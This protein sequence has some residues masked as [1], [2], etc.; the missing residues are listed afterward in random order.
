MTSQFNL[1]ISNR[2]RLVSFAP[3]LSLLI[4]GA[5]LLSGAQAAVEPA[6][7]TTQ[8][9]KLTDNG[10]SISWTAAEPVWVDSEYGHLPTIDQFKNDKRPGHFQLPQKTVTFAIP[11][12]AIIQTEIRAATPLTLA[13]RPVAI[14]PQP[15]G[16]KKNSKG[17]PIGGEFEPSTIS[18]QPTTDLV[19]ITEIGTMAGVRLATATFS[20]L[21]PTDDGLIFTP[22]A[23]VEITFKHIS[24]HRASDNRP[25]TTLQTALQTQVVN[26]DHIQ[27][28][29]STN[30]PVKRSQ[31]S[32]VSA[33]AVIQISGSGMVQLTQQHLKDAGLNVNTI[34]P[35]TLSLSHLGNTV[36][37]RWIGNSD[38]TFSTT[39]SLIFFAPEFHS[40][41]AETTPILL[42]LGSSSTQSIGTRTGSPSSSPSGALTS[43]VVIEENLL[44][45]PDCGCK[46]LP[47]GWDG[48]RWMWT[49][50]RRQKARASSSTVEAQLQ[51]VDVSQPAEMTVHQIGFTSLSGVDPDHAVR[52]RLNDTVLGTIF[53]DGKAANS[54]TFD[55]PAGLLKDA[56]TVE[57]ELIEH[58][59]EDDQPN[60][61]GVWLDALEFSYVETDATVTAQ[62]MRHGAPSA[63]SYSVNTAA[64][65]EIYDVTDP[66]QPLRLTDPASSSGS[67]S[68]ADTAANASYVLVPAGEYL[69]PVSIQPVTGI[70][71][72]ASTGGSYV[73]IAPAAFNQSPELAA[74]IN[75][76]QNQGWEVVFE[77]VEEIYAAFGSGDPN[78][79]SIQSYFEWGYHNWAVTPEMVLLVGDGS[80]DPKQ[81]KSGSAVTR[82]PP[83][84]AQV[85]PWLG[86][87]AAD[88]RFVTVDGNDIL[89]DMAIGRLPAN[90]VEELA[91]IVSKILAYA[92]TEPIGDWNS[93]MLIVADNND[94]AGDFVLSSNTLIA[95]HL[96]HPWR[97]SRHYFGVDSTSESAS[98]AEILR[99]WQGG[100]G[101]IMYTGHSSVHQWGSERL[102]HIDD[103]GNLKN[104]GRLPLVFQMTCFTGSY[105][106][107][108]FN[109]LDEQLVRQSDGG[110]IAVWGATGLGVGTGHDALA[111][112]AL[113]SIY[114]QKNPSLGIALLAGKVQLASDEPNALDLLDTFN[115]LGDPALQVNLQLTG[116]TIHLPFT[117][118]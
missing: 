84:L 66:Y 102:I 50:M 90:S 46:D 92:T 61:D 37:F 25:F 94:K 93:S 30:G 70:A 31:A 97:P 107:A 106:S 14:A 62:S 10:L 67:L 15:A 36:P 71:A 43:K 114:A 19:D 16:I 96:D 64:T 21:A 39:E 45:S 23:T 109:T 88:N 80:S 54:T 6:A 73:V 103:V 5:M 59:I 49:E 76:R 113:D 42:S 100:P 68:W 69:E 40:R 85:D 9:I 116:R 22:Q 18:I 105:H 74:L 44:Y 117:A 104:S 29:S 3:V 34:D 60:F 41:W 77:T 28:G 111:A 101:M 110:A 79:E 95:N 86:E 83:F 11:A 115:L 12:G 7:A 13:P 32:P 72:K 35:N 2:P 56:N 63:G 98:Q 89:P 51:R 27:P 33:D 38:Q 53:W 4:L 91:N 65:T 87:T 108:T 47:T 58:D 20:P 99:R 17:E 8:T 82:I 78:P 24:D 75:H 26:P 57:L 48:D 118:K 81:H 52:V 1:G 112:A 55:L